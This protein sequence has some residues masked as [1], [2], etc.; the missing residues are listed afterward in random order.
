M[1]SNIEIQGYEFLTED[2]FIP[3][4]SFV[5]HPLW[6]QFVDS[7]K[8]LPIDPYML[9]NG[10]Y[11][12]RRFGQFKLDTRTNNVV[13]VGNNAFFQAKEYNSLNGGIARQFE[14]LMEDIRNSEILAQLIRHFAN[15][16]PLVNQATKWLVNIHQIR[17]ECNSNV[18]GKATPEGIHQDGHQYVAQI[19]ITRKNIAGGESILYSSPEQELTK[20]TLENPLDTI[21]VNDKKVWHAVTPII[22]AIDKEAG[23]RD[24]LLLDYNTL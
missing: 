9:D 19:L 12:R 4:K 22:P 6:Q 21:F 1:A 20:K 23:F 11:R 5:Q 17:I 3:Q 13:W 2:D 10:K 15:K 7:W 18:A 24:M 14:P 16:L 8:I